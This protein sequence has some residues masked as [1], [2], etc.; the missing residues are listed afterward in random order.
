MSRLGKME[1]TLGKYVTLEEIVEKIERVTP[2]DVHNMAQ[3]LFRTETF[4]LTALGPVDDTV[5]PDTFTF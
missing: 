1:T 2:D 3:R 4:C 5:L